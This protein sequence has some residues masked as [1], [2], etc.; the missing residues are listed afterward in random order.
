MK[1]PKS[2]II[3]PQF[4]NLIPLLQRT[5]YLQLEENLLADG[6]RDPLVVWRGTLVDGHNRYEIC[7]RHRIPFS[8]TEVDFYCR[9]EAIAWICA[10]QLGRRN[11]SE[12]TRKYLIGKQYDSEKFVS[13]IK[14][15]S[16]L[17]Q[18]SLPEAA[19][20]GKRDSMDTS[21]QRTEYLQLE[22]NLLA[23]GCRDPLVVW[24]GTLVDGHNRYEICM[25][26]RIPFSVTEVDF[27]CREEAIAWI[28]ANQLGRRNLSEGTRKY[29][30]GK[31]YDSEK[32]VSKIKNPSGLNQYSLPE[33]AL[34][35]KRDSMDT[36][37]HR[38]ADRIADENCISAGT[39]EKYA[40]FS[41]AV[42]KIADAEPALGSKILSGQYKV[43]HKNIVALSKLEPAEMRKVDRK[44][45]RMQ[46]QPF[47]QFKKTRTAINRTLEQPLSGAGQSIKDMPVFDPDADIT[48]LTL[49]IPSWTGSIHRIQTKTDLSIISSAARSALIRELHVLVDKACEMLQILEEE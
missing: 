11:L 45:R 46:Q 44:I 23:D 2:L 5:E 3:D 27:Y 26:H 33:A 20:P 41:R 21:L 29:L 48:G 10:N 4:K 28:C 36:S 31:Q 35:G 34:P 13:K 19:L 42:D 37:R 47:V 25:R 43:S 6:C 12:G 40:I 18:Y 24:R 49:T 8:V 14:N 32:F 1:M 38:T 17:N 39:V 16:G 9:E 15:P 22:E 7:M 30:I